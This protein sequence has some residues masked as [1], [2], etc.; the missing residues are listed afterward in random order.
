MPYSHSWSK[1]S[2]GKS[3]RASSPRARSASASSSQARLDVGE[4]AAEDRAGRLGGD[5]AAD[6]GLEVL[7]VSPEIGERVAVES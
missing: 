7:H 2:A 4:H 6:R 5:Q 3:S 1:G